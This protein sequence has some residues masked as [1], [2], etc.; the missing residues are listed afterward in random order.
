MCKGRTITISLNPKLIIR[1]KRLAKAENR[2]LSNFVENK[3]S[4]LCR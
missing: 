4:K 2:S 3:L 1:L